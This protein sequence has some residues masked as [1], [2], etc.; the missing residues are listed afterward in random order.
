MVLQSNKWM[1][2][3]QKDVSKT[4]ALQKLNLVWKSYRSMYVQAILCGISKSSVS[5][6]LLPILG[7]TPELEYQRQEAG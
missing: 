5:G 1:G 3:I 7:G 4:R 6:S 2:S